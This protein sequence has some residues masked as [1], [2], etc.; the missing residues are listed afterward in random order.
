MSFQGSTAR[1]HHSHIAPLAA[2]HDTGEE[3]EGELKKQTGRLKFKKHTELLL[4]KKQ[5]S[6]PICVSKEMPKSY[7]CTH[8]FL[9]RISSIYKGTTTNYHLHP[10]TVKLFSPAEELSFAQLCS[11]T[12]LPHYSAPDHLHC[13]Q[14]RHRKKNLPKGDTWRQL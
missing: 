7:S 5:G 14:I 12:L 9:Q 13:A 8:T 1:L 11:L 2:L 3:P 6:V 10:K 4:N